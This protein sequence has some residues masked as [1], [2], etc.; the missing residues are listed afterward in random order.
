MFHLFSYTLNILLLYLFFQNST[1]S[2]FIKCKTYT[3]RLCM[4]C[5][6]GSI[7]VVS[8]LRAGWPAI[9]SL[10]GSIFLFIMAKP[11][12]GLIT[13][14]AIQGV[15]GFPPQSGRGMKSTTYLHL[16]KTK[17]AWNYAST[18]TYIHQTF[19]CL[20]NCCFIYKLDI[21]ID[22]YGKI[23]SKKILHKYTTS[24]F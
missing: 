17:N 18:H 13:Q 11:A 5:M 15:L 20:E 19:H 21:F 8:K 2:S 12:V 6:A 9:N 1:V 3:S 14:L 10:L 16:A 22:N 23:L 7:N 4:L 24:K